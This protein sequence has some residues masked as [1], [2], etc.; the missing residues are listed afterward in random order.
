MAGAEARAYQLVLSFEIIFPYHVCHPCIRLLAIALA[1]L[2]VLAI[3]F[4]RMHKRTR[5]RT[6]REHVQA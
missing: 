4:G 1:M 3:A 2:L 5:A 6:R